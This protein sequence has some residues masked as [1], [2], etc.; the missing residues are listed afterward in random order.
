MAMILGGLGR[1][2]WI[3]GI[4]LSSRHGV[5]GLARAPVQ[6]RITLPQ[7]PGLPGCSTDPG[8]GDRSIQ[9]GLAQSL[10]HSR[11]HGGWKTR[12]CKPAGGQDKIDE[13]Q[14]EDLARGWGTRA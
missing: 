1:G 8:S 13:G 11:S 7:I 6:G 5:P 14:G 3:A 2:P 9:P 12:A 4:S 10:S